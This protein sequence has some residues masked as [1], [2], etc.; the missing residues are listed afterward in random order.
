MIT[1]PIFQKE[2]TLKW[3]YKRYT[4]Y[5]IFFKYSKTQMA[6]V[7]KENNYFLDQTCTTTILF[8]YLVKNRLELIYFNVIGNHA[9]KFVLFINMY[10]ANLN[11]Y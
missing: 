11:V 5:I 1:K 2:K 10:I 7:Y 9:K 3:L 8:A 4:K 6:F